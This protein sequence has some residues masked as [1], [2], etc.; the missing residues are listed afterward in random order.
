MRT[1]SE[2]QSL[3]R[4]LMLTERSAAR[5]ET[6]RAKTEAQ[7]DSEV[8]RKALNVYEQLVEDMEQGKTLVVRDP[9]GGEEIVRLL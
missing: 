1:K 4:S 3:R 6:L 2:S 5:L 9:S 7:S 8:V